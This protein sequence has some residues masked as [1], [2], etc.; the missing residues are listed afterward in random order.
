MVARGPDRCRQASGD[1]IRP[2]PFVGIGRHDL[3][4]HANR[5]EAEEA[6]RPEPPVRCCSVDLG[7]SISIASLHIIKP[8][9][10]LMT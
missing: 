6:G 10:C 5:T 1:G 8:A 4:R 3:D 7:V 9:Y 2:Q